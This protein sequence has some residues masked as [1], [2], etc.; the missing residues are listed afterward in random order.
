MLILAMNVSFSAQDRKREPLGM[1]GI[2]E[3]DGACTKRDHRTYTTE[4]SII[5]VTL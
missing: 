4:D 2:L 5:R 1:R 3:L